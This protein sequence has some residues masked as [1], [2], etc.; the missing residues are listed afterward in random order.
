MS[1]KR[2]KGYVF[3]TYAEDHPPFHVHIL[4]STGRNIGRF[5]IEHQCPMDDFEVTKRLKRALIELGYM[6]EETKK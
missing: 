1:R 3:I 5:D 6:K 4:T 2:Y